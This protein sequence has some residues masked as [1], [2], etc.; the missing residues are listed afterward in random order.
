MKWRGGL[1]QGGGIL[2]FTAM[3]TGVK[4]MANCP[5][6]TKPLLASGEFGGVAQFR[7][8]CPSC[9]V[10]VRVRVLPQILVEKMEEEA[11]SHDTYPDGVAST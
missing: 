11:V 2:F 6:C 7:M 1:E 4:K 8:R 5:N 9:Q 10:T 3:E